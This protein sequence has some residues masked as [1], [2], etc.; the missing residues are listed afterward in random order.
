[1]AIQRLR[2]VVPPTLAELLEDSTYAA[3]FRRN[4]L[5]PPNVRSATPWQIIARRVPDAHGSTWALKM[6][7]AYAD[8]Y[9]RV[10]SMLRDAQWE[11]V[12]ICSRAAMFRPPFDF[13]WGSRFHWCGRCRRPS[14]FQPMQIHPIMRGQMDSALLHAIMLATET[15]ERCYYC[16]V[17]RSSMPH[18]RPRRR[19]K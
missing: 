7:P 1:M 13:E 18:Y 6:M 12:A 5:M 10:R 8:A 16:G 14:L 17:R 19:A 2:L 4:P 15:P 11:D 9:R 3:W